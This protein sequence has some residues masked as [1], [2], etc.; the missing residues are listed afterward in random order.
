MPSKQKIKGA[1]WER[2]VAKHLTEIYG[3]TFIRVPHS[4]AYIGGSNKL[5][6]KYQLDLFQEA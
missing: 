3:E 1:T 5:R 2:D 4:G 6:K